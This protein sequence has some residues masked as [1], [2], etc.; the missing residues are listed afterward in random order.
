MSIRSIQDSAL[1]NSIY[2]SS[3]KVG[4]PNF[5]IFIISS[6]LTKSPIGEDGFE[7]TIIE[8]E[9]T[10]CKSSLVGNLIIL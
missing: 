8:L 5:K 3:I 7:N 6:L 9:S 1:E 2:A 10:S 4:N